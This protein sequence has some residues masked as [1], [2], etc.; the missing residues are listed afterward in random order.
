VDHVVVRDDVLAGPM[1][2]ETITCLLDLHA[3]VQVMQG[4]GGRL[5]RFAADLNP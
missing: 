3:P 4:S 1:P 2:R 5:I